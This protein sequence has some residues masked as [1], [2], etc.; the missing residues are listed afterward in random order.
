VYIYSISYYDSIEIDY[1]GEVNKFLKNARRSVIC[2]DFKAR[3]GLP[4]SG[5]AESEA[6]AAEEDIFR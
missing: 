2:V 6:N 3:G 5:Q 1:I 4:G